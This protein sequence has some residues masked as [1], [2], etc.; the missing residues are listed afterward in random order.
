MT[1][2]SVGPA[3][4]TSVQDRGSAV[5][6]DCSARPSF[7]AS[8][9]TTTSRDCSIIALLNKGLIQT[10]FAKSAS[11]YDTVGAHEGPVCGHAPLIHSIASGPTVPMLSART[12]PPTT[13]SSMSGS[14]ARTGKRAR[15]VVMTRRRLPRSNRA[16]ASTVVPA[17]RMRVS[18]SLTSSTAAL[19]IACF[20]RSCASRR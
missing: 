2:S 17:S 12:E 9:R 13:I 14:F 8:A 10:C 20:S 4:V 11:G 3:L 5:Q 1:R 7:V 6:A 19:A 15:F 18:P 16:N